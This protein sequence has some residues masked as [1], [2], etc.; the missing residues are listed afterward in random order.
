[1]SRRQSKERES[2][3]GCLDT[4]ACCCHLPQDIGD[5][6]ATLLQEQ[7]RIEQAYAARYQQ[8]RHAI[9]S[10]RERED[11]LC[12]QREK[13]KALTSRLQHLDKSNPASPRRQ[14]IEKERD[15]LSK[16]AHEHELALGDF[17]R[18]ML[19]EA[20][21]LRFNAMDEYADKMKMIAGF[22][23]YI[24]DLLDIEPTPLAPGSS[25]AASTSPTS[26]VRPAYVGE[27]QSKLILDDCMLALEQWT[28]SEDEERPTLAHLL[29]T[30]LDDDDHLDATLLSDLDIHDNHHRFRP[31]REPQNTYPPPLPTPQ[32]ECDVDLPR[33]EKKSDVSGFPAPLTSPSSLPVPPPS[34]ESIS[35]NQSRA[36]DNNDTLPPPRHSPADVDYH[37]LFHAHGPTLSRQPSSYRRPSYADY[38]RSYFDKKEANR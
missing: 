37:Q 28:P 20:F 6:L 32:D 35:T 24:V 16:E 12:D 26:P 2:C 9:K 30:P 17:K 21:Y 15:V 1:M 29:T 31:R 13:L 8:Y 22:G 38:S 34:Y 5:R 14:T 10:I 19:R 27:T 4:D 7:A 25:A 18:C 11:R 36:D 23:K 33:D 3:H